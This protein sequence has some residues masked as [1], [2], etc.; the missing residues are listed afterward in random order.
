MLKHLAPPSRPRAQDVGSVQAVFPILPRRRIV[1]LF[2]ERLEKVKKP[3][4]FIIGAPKCGTTSLAWWLSEHP[5]IFM[6]PIKEPHFYCSDFNAGILVNRAEYDALFARAT[7][8]HAAVGEASTSYLYSQ[9]AIPNI[10]KE[11]AEPRYIAMVRNPVEMAHAQY[12]QVYQD[13]LE[14]I[15]DFA[16]AW[17]LSQERAQGRQVTRWCR[18]PKF[19]DYKS[20]CKLGQQLARLFAIVPRERVL[21]LILD[22]VKENPRGEYLKVL[23]FLGVEDD[24]RREFPVKNP[25][26]ENRSFLLQ[27]AVR[28]LVNLFLF[29]KRKVGIPG[30]SYLN[31]F[32]HELYYQLYRR[33]NTRPRPRAPL[34]PRLRAEMAEYFRDDVVLLSQLLQ[35][36]LTGWLRTSR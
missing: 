27:K 31:I 16:Q 26:K 17:E 14:H 15:K 9:V 3:N 5:R 20:I 30:S 21:V 10:E 22:E 33:L 32:L 2:F 19:L 25:A 29:G 28:P 23:H 36:D 4:F 12:E 11:L 8:I 24:G 6:S 13:G 18:E 7:D 1:D 35:Q 34:P